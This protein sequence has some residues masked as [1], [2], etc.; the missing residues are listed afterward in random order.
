MEEK[1]SE[2]VSIIRKLFKD[3]TICW[4]AKFLYGK[5]ENLAL[6]NEG[7]CYATDDFFK[8]EY[9]MS[10]RNVSRWLKK[11][12]DGGY[13][14]KEK[15]LRFRRMVRVLIPK[16]FINFSDKI[17]QEDGQNCLKK[18]TKMSACNYMRRKSEINSE[19]DGK[20][21]AT[22]EEV[23][24]LFSFLSRD[25]VFSEKDLIFSKEEYSQLIEKIKESE[26][27]MMHP[28][29]NFL[30]WINKHSFNILKGKHDNHDYKKKDKSPNMTFVSRKQSE[31]E[32]NDL[33]GR[34]DDLLF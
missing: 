10:E 5:I 23:K 9:E 13:I 4:G 2:N 29:I 3:K 26:W 17:V 15:K 25:L 16:I 18:K 14:V 8:K 22:S 33:F 6:N 24:Q 11:L 12:I 27:L 19:R 31:E 32:T 30:S 7:F 1:S 21:R 34:L 20:S 28:Q